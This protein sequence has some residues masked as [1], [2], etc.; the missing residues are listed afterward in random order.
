MDVRSEWYRP[1]LPPNLLPST[2]V[3]L[4]AYPRRALYTREVR[5]DKSRLQNENRGSVL[6]TL[7]NREP[8]KSRTRLVRSRVVGIAS[9]AQ[10]LL[11]PDG[12][13]QP[14][15]SVLNLYVPLLGRGSETGRKPRAY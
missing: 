7:R 8:Q 4:A 12:L 2:A 6:P 11:S 15:V 1:R 3:L 9:S 13:L 14:Y 10:L 5:S